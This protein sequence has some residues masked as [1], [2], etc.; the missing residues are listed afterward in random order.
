MFNRRNK[1][2]QDRRGD[3]MLLI[4]GMPVFH[5]ELKRTGVPV[6]E[7]SNQIEK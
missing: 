4:N 3:L 5:M 1:I 6:Y 7:A 2:L